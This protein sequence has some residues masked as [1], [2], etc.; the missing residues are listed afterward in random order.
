MRVSLPRSGR[1]S[2]GGHDGSVDGTRARRTRKPR[3]SAARTPPSFRF[4]F[5]R[6]LFWF[7]WEGWWSVWW[8]WCVPFV[9]LPDGPSAGSS[10]RRGC[11]AAQQ[12]LPCDGC[13]WRV[14]FPQ[15][16]PRRD[17]ASPAFWSPRQVWVVY[18]CPLA[19]ATEGRTCAHSICCEAPAS[20]SSTVVDEVLGLLI[21][22]PRKPW[23]D[24][25]I[26]VP[27]PP[28]LQLVRCRETAWELLSCKG[29]HQASAP[30]KSS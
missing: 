10:R 8:W 4:N 25:D 9:F 28:Q 11:I 6:P 21:P 22:K 23:I 1:G 20:P 17:A 26:L 3:V 14:W 12:R 2:G 7:G 24:R 16:L 30:V 27:S 13:V 19:P 15:P 5:I 18:C 29:Q